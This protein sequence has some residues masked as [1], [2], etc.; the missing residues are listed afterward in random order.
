MTTTTPSRPD[1]SAVRHLF[2]AASALEGAP[3]DAL[4]ADP[5]HD[6]AVV[7]EV[8][9]LLGY[10]AGPSML[11]QPVSGPAAAAPPSREGQR[12]GAW[13]LTGLLGS[14]GMGEVWAAERDDG[15]YAGQA[16]IKLLKRGM[17]SEA[18]LARFAQEQ[19]A[20]ARLSHPHIAHLLDAGLSPDGLPYFVMERIDGRPI[21]EAC[22]GQ[23]LEARLRL[24]FATLGEPALFLCHAKGSPAPGVERD[25]PT[26]MCWRL[27]NA[28]SIASGNGWL[29]AK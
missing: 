13:R 21:E 20:L 4:L 16:A 25:P 28:Q 24:V 9:S 6:P 12:L 3:R 7:R 29:R 18:V 10:E 15:R 8:R 27:S 11:D 1:W 23:P 19:Q 26:R 22:A 14:G 5:A 17:D 2:E